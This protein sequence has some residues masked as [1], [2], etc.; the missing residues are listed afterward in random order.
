MV[1]EKIINFKNG[2]KIFAIYPASFINRMVKN[3]DNPTWQ[4]FCRII[5]LLII[6][7]LILLVLPTTPAGTQTRT[8]F[9]TMFLSGSPWVQV[10]N[11]EASYQ[12][13]SRTC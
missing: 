5:V 10:P 6:V 9:E 11:K 12:L 3:Y 4:L 2:D 8:C 1:G 7:L 13:H